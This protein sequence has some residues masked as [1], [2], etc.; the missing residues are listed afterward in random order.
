MTKDVTVFGTRD[1]FDD[2]INEFL[3]INTTLYTLDEFFKLYDFRPEVPGY[4]VSNWWIGKDGTSV[5]EFAFTGVDKADLEVEVINQVLTVTSKPRQS[6]IKGCEGYFV[7]RN[8][9]KKEASVS[10]RLSDR[11]DVDKITTTFKEGLLT[12]KIP[13]KEEVKPIR[14]QISID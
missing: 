3:G 7:Y 11:Q 2:F 4:P 14:K 6:E 12:I 10:I 9:S 8:F 1:L 13:L 5:F